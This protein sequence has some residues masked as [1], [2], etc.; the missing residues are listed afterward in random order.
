MGLC[1]I[2]HPTQRV[3]LDI[4]R[5]VALDDCGIYATSLELHGVERPG[6]PAALVGEQVNV[7]DPRPRERRLGE[8]PYPLRRIERPPV[9]AAFV[10]TRAGSAPA[11]APRTDRPSRG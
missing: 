8:L 2:V 1:L 7:D 9:C 5:G 6:E 4:E 10:L 11:Y 3:P